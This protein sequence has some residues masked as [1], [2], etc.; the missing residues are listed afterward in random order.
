MPCDVIYIYGVH[1]SVFGLVV[2]NESFVPKVVLVK[3]ATFLALIYDFFSLVYR[4]TGTLVTS[5]M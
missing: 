5:C 1:M 2:K 4:A 3:N